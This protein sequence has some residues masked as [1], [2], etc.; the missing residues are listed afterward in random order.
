MIIFT[1]SIIS[2]MNI[3]LYKIYFF[4]GT[5]SISAHAH[6]HVRAHTHTY[7]LRW[8]RYKIQSMDSM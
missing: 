2:H 6:M 4:K 8:I 3:G 5:Q 1:M 7:I